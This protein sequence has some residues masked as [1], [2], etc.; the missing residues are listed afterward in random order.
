MGICP[1]GS[2]IVGILAPLDGLRCIGVNLIRHGTRALD[3]NG[4]NFG[5]WGMGGPPIGGLIAQGNLLAPGS[6]FT[7]ET[8]HWQVYYREIGALVCMTGQNTTN[9]VTTTVFP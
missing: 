2:G 6:F 7:G 1:P 5:P 3:G 4:A 9:G 8:R